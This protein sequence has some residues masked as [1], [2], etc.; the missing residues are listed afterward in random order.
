MCRIDV[1]NI[2]S[3][4]YQYYDNVLKYI[5]REDHCTNCNIGAAHVLFPQ[6]KKDLLSALRYQIDA[7]RTF[8]GK[9]D[10]RLGIHLTIAFSADELAF[11]D[12]D[13][14]LD[15][16]Y[17][18]SINEFTNCITFFGVHDNTALLH[19]HMLIIPI[20]IKLGTMYGCN[21][22][23]WYAIEKRLRIYMTKYIPEVVL[24]K[25]VGQIAYGG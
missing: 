3:G 11:L 8:Y 12:A 22:Q 13:K 14:I 9:E 6:K 15:I 19:L 17:Y 2:M 1:R 20:N 24:G 21:K 25:E 7:V 16:G 10:N 4:N 18:L 5:A 23:G